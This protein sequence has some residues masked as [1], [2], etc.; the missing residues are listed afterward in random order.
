MVSHYFPRFLS[1]SLVRFAWFSLLCVLSCAEVDGFEWLVALAILRGRDAHLVAVLEVPM[2]Q[3]Q[4][5][6][7][8]SMMV[9]AH[10]CSAFLRL[11][12]PL[13]VP[14]LNL[15]LVLAFHGNLLRSGCGRRCRLV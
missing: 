1:H 9:A 12:V 2:E 5:A 3:L 15:Q 8:L 13:A 11:D 4:L 14:S 10:S 6:R 7:C